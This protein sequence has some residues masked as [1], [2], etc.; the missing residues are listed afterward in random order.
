MDEFDLINKYFSRPCHDNSVYL[1]VGDDAALVKADASQALAI[2]VDTLVEGVHFPIKTNP[3]DIAYKAVAVNLSD[4]AAMGAEPKWITLALTLPNVNI[5]WLEN[6]SKGLY[7]CCGAYHVSL[8]GGDTTRGSLSVTIQAHGFVPLDKSLQRSGAKVGDR[9]YVTGELG[10]ATLGLQI[11]LNKLTVPESDRKKLITALNRPEP[12]VKQG[13]LLRDFANSCIDISDG[14][15]ADLQHILEV[16]HVGA[17]ID[18]A[19]IPLSPLSSK[20]QLDIN[21]KLQAALTGG[22]DYQLCFTIPVEKTAAFE[23]CFQ[24]KG[25]AYF[26]VGEI[27]AKQG[28]EFLATEQYQLDLSSLGYQHFYE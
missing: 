26:C 23:Q 4:L 6:F 5:D 1:G 16:S 15:L 14:F 17:L 21:Q 2:C 13:L 22:D 25:L 27:V 7:D 18:L 12:C 8:I 9:I 28:I 11:I 24:A 19:K 3:E 10:L 20:V